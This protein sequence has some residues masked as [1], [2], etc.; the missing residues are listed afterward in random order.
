MSARLCFV[1]FLLISL[2]SNTPL[3]YVCQYVLILY[4]SGLTIDAELTCSASIS[5]LSFIPLLSTLLL[6][7]VRPRRKIVKKGLS[8]T[9]M[10]VGKS[11]LFE[12]G[13]TGEAMRE[14]YHSTS[15]R[16]PGST[17]GSYDI[18]RRSKILC[19]NRQASLDLERG[20]LTPQHLNPLVPVH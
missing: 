18:L 1:S 6:C 12:P 5:P 20:V 17:C 13:D 3:N 11:L 2:N 16:P 10:V 8:F 9:C 19:A 7:T 14:L 15:T 4:R